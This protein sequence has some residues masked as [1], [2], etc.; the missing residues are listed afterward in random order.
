MAAVRGIE[1]GTLGMAVRLIRGMEELVAS[2]SQL[3]WGMAH[4]T[5]RHWWHQGLTPCR[6]LLEA[7]FGIG[8]CYQVGAADGD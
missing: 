7:W 4:Q 2:G 8:K 3:V 6:R 5:W 1:S